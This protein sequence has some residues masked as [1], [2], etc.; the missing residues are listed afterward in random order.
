MDS[1]VV[2]CIGWHGGGGS[3]RLAECIQYIGLNNLFPPVIKIG[4]MR[5]VLS[6]AFSGL[7]LRFQ[8]KFQELS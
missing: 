6:I 5:V 4:T 1:G 2:L 3:I 8:A 7:I